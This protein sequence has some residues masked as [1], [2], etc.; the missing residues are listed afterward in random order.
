M[1]TNKLTSLARLAMVV[2]ILSSA[3]ALATPT[4]QAAGGPTLELDIVVTR[5]QVYDA[6][7]GNPTTTVSG[8]VEVDM[9]SVDQTGTVWFRLGNGT[10]T[11]H[12]EIGDSESWIPYWGVRETGNLVSIFS[13]YSLPKV[14]WQ[15]EQQIVG[16]VLLRIVEEPIE[17]SFTSGTGNFA[18]ADGDLNGTPEYLSDFNDIPVDRTDLKIYGYGGDCVARVNGE[19]Q[20]LGTDADLQITSGGFTVTHGT[21]GVFSSE[22]LAFSTSGTKRS[23]SSTV[24]QANIGGFAMVLISLL[25]IAWLFGRNRK[26]LAALIAVI[27]LVVVSLTTTANVA[28]AGPQPTPTPGAT[29]IATQPAPTAIPPTLEPTTAPTL[30]PTATQAAPTTEAP[31]PFVTV[32]VDKSEVHVGETVTF[33][34][35][36]ENMME[37]E[38][39]WLV[40]TAGLQFNTGLIANMN[41]QVL[42]TYVWTPDTQGTY[43]LTAAHVSQDGITVYFSND[44][45][46]VTVTVL[47]AEPTTLAPTPEPA[48]TQPPADTVRERFIRAIL[49]AVGVVLLLIAVGLASLLLFLRS[50]K[51]K[52][53]KSTDF[54]VVE[55]TPAATPPDE[56]APQ[57]TSLRRQMPTRRQSDEGE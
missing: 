39:I 41:G 13:V 49:A 9:F 44:A 53:K 55:E 16:K 24:L 56:E 21:C 43:T 38:S 11:Y 6:P 8:T 50:R 35:T 36:A 57:G 5:L 45:A 30:E 22:N 20:V 25:A 26:R 28:M 48:V 19:E 29:T 10:A 31:Q 51:P 15:I 1:K 46:T 54:E 12:P 27:S 42:G 17:F 34:V 23:F 33:T 4:A 37:G 52:D 40:P 32:S 7:G 3:F 47:S 18:T 14:Y 2:A